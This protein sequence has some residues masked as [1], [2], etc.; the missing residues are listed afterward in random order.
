MKIYEYGDPDA[1]AVLIQP[2]DG[3]DPAGIEKE[4][5]LIAE[6]CSS[7][8]RLTAVVVDDWNADLSPWRSPAVFGKTDFDGRAEATLD[9]ILELCAEKNRTYYI[10]GYSLAALFALWAAYQTDVFSGVAAASPSVWFPGF[11]DYMKEHA[12]RTEAV[13]LSLGDREEKARDPV[14]A[15]VGIRIREAYDLLSGR[16]VNCTLVWNEGNHFRDADLRTARAFAWV[17]RAQAGQKAV[18]TETGVE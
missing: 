14:L 1:K 17:L 15:T 6:S 4:V 11:S 16:G 8:F 9:M 2:V 5:S 3:H 12:I 13:Y 7:A 10:G 18:L